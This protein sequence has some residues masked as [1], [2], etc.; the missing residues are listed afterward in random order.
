MGQYVQG[1][2]SAYISPQCYGKLAISY[3]WQKHYQ[4]LQVMPAVG[5]PL[6]EARHTFYLHLLL[7]AAATYEGHLPWNI[8]IKAGPVFECL[9]HNKLA[10]TAALLPAYYCLK[11][12]Y[13]HWG[14]TGTMGLKIT[15]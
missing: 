4:A 15:F 6:M 10:L 12:P 14:Y 7:G 11:N 13:G 8:A 9:L 1:D 3:T 2:Y 5:L